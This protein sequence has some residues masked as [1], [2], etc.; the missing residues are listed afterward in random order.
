MGV[1]LEAKPLGRAHWTL[2][3]A[4]GEFVFGDPW[5]L[6]AQVYDEGDGV[7]LLECGKGKMWVGLVEEVARA[8]LPLGFETVRWVRPG[9]KEIRVN[10]RR[11]ARK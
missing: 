1:H 5:E 2:R 8:L 3:A 10:V 7:A 11:A 4:R 6:S 9:G